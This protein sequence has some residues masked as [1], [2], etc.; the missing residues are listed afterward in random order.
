MAV[1]EHLSVLLF[2]SKFQVMLPAGS[3]QIFNHILGFAPAHPPTVDMVYVNGPTVAAGNLAGDEVIHPV[4]KCVHVYF[5][6]GFHSKSD[7]SL[8]VFGFTSAGGMNF[9]ISLHESHL[10]C[11]PLV[12]I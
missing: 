9:F 5:N 11:T 6:V 12:G 8:P 3:H 1:N 2:I 10:F 4:A 7:I